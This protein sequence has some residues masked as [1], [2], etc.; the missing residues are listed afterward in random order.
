MQPNSPFIIFLL[1]PS[2]VERIIRAHLL[3]NSASEVWLSCPGVKASEGYITPTANTGFHP[4]CQDTQVPGGDEGD[5]QGWEMPT[6]C[7]SQV[8]PGKSWQLRKQDTF[9]ILFTN[10]RRTKC[11]R[12]SVSDFLKSRG[13]QNQLRSHSINRDQSQQAK[14]W[15]SVQAQRKPP[16]FYNLAIQLASCKLTQRLLTA[17]RWDSHAP[18]APGI[19]PEAPNLKDS[20]YNS[21]SKAFSCGQNKNR[22]TMNI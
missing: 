1:F 18:R 19:Q 9:P 14:H 7:V 10:T 11:I 20:A 12:Q 2:A 21:K 13:A 15:T 5:E 16:S 22:L 8:G 6:A 17:P 4:S 3:S